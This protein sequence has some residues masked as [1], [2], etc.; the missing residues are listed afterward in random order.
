[1]ADDAPDIMNRTILLLRNVRVAWLLTMLSPAV[2]QWAIAQVSPFS[3]AEDESYYYIDHYEVAID[4]SVTEAWP[5]VV[6]LSAWIPG[7]QG[8][9]GRRP[10][11]EEGETFLLYDQFS[12]SVAKVV[13]EQLVVMV[14]LPAVQQREETQGVVM[15]S[16]RQVGE[17]TIV[18]LFMSRVFFWTDAT[19]NVLRATRESKEFSEQRKATYQAMLNELKL[20]AE[21]RE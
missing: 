18:S 13:P 7:L 8:L 19:E 5:L 4:K 16:A 11:A 9:N 3:S 20:V 12:M 10:M 17:R 2:A 21:S 14:N 15:L 1:M 6:D